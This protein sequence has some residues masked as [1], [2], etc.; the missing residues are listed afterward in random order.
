M[1][2]IITLVMLL[3][4][5]S[6]CYY[7]KEEL[8][9]G[10][11]LPCDTASVTF[12]ATVNS[13]LDR[14]NCLNCHSGNN[15]SANINLQGYANARAAAGGGRLIGSINH[16]AGFSPMPQGGNKMSACDINKIKAWIDGGMINN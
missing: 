11:N 14:N 1:K 12:S 10:V 8:L 9:Y 5:L 6:G 15:P 2:F 7:D 16:A 3:L 4:L 13:I